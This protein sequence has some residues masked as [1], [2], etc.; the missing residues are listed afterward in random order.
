VPIAI[1]AV[2]FCYSAMAPEKWQS[3]L[4]IGSAKSFGSFAFKRTLK[5]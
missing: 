1:I 5:K 3:A 2:L 4:A